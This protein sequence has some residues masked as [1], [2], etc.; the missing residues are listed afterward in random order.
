MGWGARLGA[1]AT[2][3]ASDGPIP[4][5]DIIGAGIIAKGIY[6]MCTAK[7]CPPCEPYPV[8]TIGYQGPEVGV[9]GQD[10][11]TPHYNLYQVEQIPSSCKCIWKE[12]TKA[13]SGNHHYYTQPN[14]AM[15]V[16]LNGS[17]RP[18]NYPR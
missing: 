2:A 3:A 15:G 8:G 7:D 9:K 13:L 17:S 1:A 12:K 11:G 10:A 5:G 14:P 6:D 4:I 18:P 16:N